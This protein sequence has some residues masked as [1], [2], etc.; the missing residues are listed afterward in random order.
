MESSPSCQVSSPSRNS[1]LLWNPRLQCQVH[2]SFFLVIHYTW[3]QSM[4][5]QLNLL[6]STL[7]L[8]VHVSQVNLNVHTFYTSRFDLVLCAVDV[9]ATMTG[10]SVRRE[11]KLRTCGNRALKDVRHSKWQEDGENCVIGSS[12]F[13]TLKPNTVVI[14]WWWMRWA[15]QVERLGDM[16]NEYTVF[17]GNREVKSPD[18]G[19]SHRRKNNVNMV[20]LLSAWWW[21][22][23]ISKWWGNFLTRWMT[24]TFLRG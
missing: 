23:G 11:Y 17:I 14:K 5:S 7:K 21:T 2:M 10:K 16:R 22:F 4:R 20:G 12:V 1:P 24:V 9:S 6:R 13:C 8:S 18:R 19:L 3:L 15:R